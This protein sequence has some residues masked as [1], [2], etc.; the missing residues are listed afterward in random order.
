MVIART[1]TGQARVRQADRRDA[2]LF[3]QV[4]AHKTLRRI[5]FP[6]RKPRKNEQ[7]RPLD[8]AILS[9][10]GEGLTASANGA[11]QFGQELRQLE[12]KAVASLYLAL[13]FLEPQAKEARVK[14]QSMKS[15]QPELTTVARI[16]PPTD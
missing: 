12:Q 8:L 14:L 6:V 1:L 10:H 15:D 4:E 5:L 16:V 2:V 9:T 13:Y 11:Q 7:M 3:V